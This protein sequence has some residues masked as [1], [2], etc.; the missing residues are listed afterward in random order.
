M[1]IERLAIDDPRAA[2]LLEEHEHTVFQEPDWSM[3][4]HEGLGHDV[5]WYGLV[6]RDGRL[7]LA[8]PGIELK[9]KLLKLFYSH[10]AYGGFVGEAQLVPTFIEQMPEAFRRH[11]VH[12]V[13]ITQSAF[14]DHPEPVGLRHIPAQQHVLHFE[15]RSADDLWEGFKGRVRRD[16][17]RAKNRGGIVV[18][19][20]TDSTPF[21]RIL[22]LYRE[23]M[24]RN[25]SYALWNERILEQV[26]KRYV[27]PGKGEILVADKDGTLVAAMVILFSKRVSH[28]LIGVS[29]FEYRSDCPNDLVTWEAIRRT[30]ERGH[31]AFDFMTSGAEDDALAAFKA[32][33]DSTEHDLHFWEADFSPT[34][35]WLYRK[36]L[37]FAKS[38]FGS[39]L[40]R[41]L[42]KR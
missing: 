15:G 17:R 25:N 31:E 4:L 16:V 24:Q 30:V 2:A 6:D 42:Y 1:K 7:R 9:L 13:R 3:T 22:E 29:D 11:G 40:M 20:A 14:E 28:W 35:A 18:T 26:L 37:G 10:I 38:K 34:R 23:V 39:T 36:A 33:F 27:K 21:G 19:E 32:K 41:K 12:A 5:A 8:L